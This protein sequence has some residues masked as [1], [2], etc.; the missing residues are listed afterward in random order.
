MKFMAQFPVVAVLTIGLLSAGAFSAHAEQGMDIDVGCRT[1]E[2]LQTF[3]DTVTPALMA[4]ND[5]GVVYARALNDIELA[6][7][8]IVADSGSF[9]YLDA[10]GVEG[11]SNAVVYSDGTI[12]MHLFVSTP[13]MDD[14]TDALASVVTQEK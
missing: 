12:S 6:A 7:S 14:D 13:A 8:C 11:M 9:H 2:S 4:G 5:I 3:Q 10:S 1:T